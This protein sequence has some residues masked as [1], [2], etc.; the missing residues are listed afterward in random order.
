MVVGLHNPGPRVKQKIMGGE[1]SGGKQ[2]RIS[3]VGRRKRVLL[4]RDKI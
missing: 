3:Q 4:T 1:C 2:L